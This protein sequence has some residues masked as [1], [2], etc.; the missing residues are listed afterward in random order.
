MFDCS[1]QRDVEESI[2]Q[3]Q[4]KDHE[5]RSVL[6]KIENSDEVNID[7]VI[8]PSAPLYKQLVHTF[9]MFTKFRPDFIELWYFLQI[10]IICSY[11]CI[12]LYFLFI[13]CIFLYFGGKYKFHALIYHML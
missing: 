3:L 12:L 13:S 4:L 1:L 2:G 10:P 5:L 6:S 8:Q 7:E 11:F 9:V